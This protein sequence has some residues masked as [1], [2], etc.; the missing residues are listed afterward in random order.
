MTD[1]S[2][3]AGLACT[4]PPGCTTGT[5]WSDRP[6]DCDPDCQPCSRMAG[7]PYTPPNGHHAARVATCQVCGAEFTAV[8]SDARFCGATCRQRHHRGHP[9]CHER[10]DAAQVAPDGALDNDPELWTGGRPGA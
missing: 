4:C 9:P 2:L 6:R 8:R 1:W 7:K 10:E 5:R 3:L